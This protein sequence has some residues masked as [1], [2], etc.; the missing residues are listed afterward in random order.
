MSRRNSF[1]K[2]EQLHLPDPCRHS[3]TEVDPL[4]PPEP[5]RCSASEVGYGQHKK[6]DA[7]DCDN[8]HRGVPLENIDLSTRRT[9]PVQQ[10]QPRVQRRSSQETSHAIV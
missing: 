3:A 8:N 5:R 4:H 6:F 10:Q 2:I 7:T 1:A 9:D